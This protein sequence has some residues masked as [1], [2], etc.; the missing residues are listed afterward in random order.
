[1]PLPDEFRD[2]AYVTLDEAAEI[3]RASR[4]QVMEMCRRGALPYVRLG[5]GGPKSDVRI[6]LDGLLAASANTSATRRE[7]KTLTTAG[8]GS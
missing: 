4:W 1:V 7:S 3:L 5:V 8:A 2:R 6:S